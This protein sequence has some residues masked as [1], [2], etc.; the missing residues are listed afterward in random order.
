MMKRNS[1][2]IVR[3]DLFFKSELSLDG[4]NLD[5]NNEE[6]LSHSRFSSGSIISYNSNS[7]ISNF[8]FS[9]ESNSSFKEDMIKKTKS[10]NNKK[11]KY[12]F[13][14]KCKKFYIIEFDSYNFL[15]FECDCEKINNCT[16]D[17]FI[18]EYT[19]S[20]KEEVEKYINCKKHINEK[21]LIYCKDCKCDL[22]EKCVNEVNEAKIY[23]NYN[24]IIKKHETHGKIFLEEEINKE[25]DKIKS[26][27]KIIR[28]NISKIDIRRIINLIINLIKTHKNYYCYNIYQSFVNTFEFLSNY[29]IPIFK[30]MIKIKTIK[31]F[32]ENINGKNFIMSIIIINQ[33]LSDLSAFKNFN[34]YFLTE[35]NLNENEIEDISP[36]EHCN[37]QN[38][39]TFDIEINKLNNNCL[40]TFK[41]ISLPNVKWLNLFQN[42]I[43]S[44]EIL[45]IIK[46]YQN[47]ESFFIGENKF[48]KNEIEKNKIYDFPPKLKEFGLTG[49]LTHET[50]DFIFKLKIEKLEILYISRN[51]LKNLSFIKKIK[52]EKLKEFWASFNDIEDLKEIENLQSKETIQRIILKKNNISNIENILEIVN[53]FPNLK[54][55]NLENN[56]IKIINEKIL[57]KLQEKEILLK[58]KND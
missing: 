21:Y 14:Q 17:K 56:P 42:N 12:I 10:K 22:C 8:R 20:D 29:K 3:N 54:E 43:K 52:F 31:E 26:Q 25:I 57:Q 38:L 53:K 6:N 58:L 19:F 28:E 51:Y 23:T 50:V 11:P 46:K 1:V 55:I 18:K 2:E 24:I 35:L 41:K 47:L 45:E 49:N 34:S 15:N 44:T 48:D 37:F 36:L 32:E 9:I 13:C 39:I 30:K 16:I 27:L 33:K 40:D 5:I 4:N 7:S